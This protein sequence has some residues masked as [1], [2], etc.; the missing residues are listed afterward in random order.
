VN[1]KESNIGEV[2]DLSRLGAPEAILRMMYGHSA[3][4]NSYLSKNK[5][6]LPGVDVE[7]LSKNL[8]S[9]EELLAAAIY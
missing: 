8:K 6:K 5:L 1:E 2:G 4:L 7:L 3:Q 9:F